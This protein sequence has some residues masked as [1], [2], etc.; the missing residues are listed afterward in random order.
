MYKAYRKSLISLRERFIDTYQFP[1]TI[2]IKVIEKYPHLDEQ[3]VNQVINGLREYFHICNI[4]G[5]TMVSMPSKVVDVAWHEFILFTKQYEQFCNKALGRFLHH[6]P[7]EAMSTPTKAQKGIK[8]A[9]KISCY[10]EQI[11]PTSPECLPIIFA[12]DS[13]LEIP[14]GF[15][16]LLNCKGQGDGVYCGGNIGCSS[17]CGGEGEGGCA[18]DSGDSDG[19]GGGGCGGD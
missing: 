15:K 19:C 10:R 4:A 18:G 2:S 3:Q 12:L 5:K 16:Y 14:D 11:S 6:V 8:K 17:G 13:Q 9:W 1:E 7:A